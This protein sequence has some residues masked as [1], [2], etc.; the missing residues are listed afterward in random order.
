MSGPVSPY[1][2][3]KAYP[4]ACRTLAFPVLSPTPTHS[5]PAFQEQVYPSSHKIIT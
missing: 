5:F 3:G 2:C 1:A 4:R